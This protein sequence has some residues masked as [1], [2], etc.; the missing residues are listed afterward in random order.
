MSVLVQSQVEALACDYPDYPDCSLS[1]CSPAQPLPA[2][3]LPESGRD[4]W[5][6]HTPRAYFQH[7]APGMPDLG[8]SVSHN[9]PTLSH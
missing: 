6:I 8:L 2:G 1:L 3:T 7:K 9:L 4:I 5:E